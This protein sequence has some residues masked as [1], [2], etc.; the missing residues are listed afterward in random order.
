MAGKALSKDQKREKQARGLLR[1]AVDFH[2]HSAPDVFPRLLSDIEI[3]RQA[4]RAGMAAVLIKSHVTMTADRAKIA[5]EVSRFPVFGGITLNRQVGGLNALAVESAAKMGA[6]QVWMPTLHAAH[7]VRNR[8]KLTPAARAMVKT[9]KGISIFRKD[10]K[11]V[12]ELELVLSAVSEYRMILGTGHL[13]P[14][15][16]L[17][18]IRQ[19]RKAGVKRIVVTHPMARFVGYSLELMRKALSLGASYLEFVLNDC[20]PRVGEPIPLGDFAGAIR[21]IGPARIILASDSGQVD[22]P[23][24]VRMMAEYIG[25]LLELGLSA[26]DIR[27]MISVNPQKILGL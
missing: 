25:R 10:G 18:L 19:A 8:E 16:G 3:A 17:A 14:E 26:K 24:P 7:T 4:K 1:G 5:Q 12:P 22:N 21:A 15:E 6:R 11:F 20:A 27:Q 2:I 13:S 9:E 23:P